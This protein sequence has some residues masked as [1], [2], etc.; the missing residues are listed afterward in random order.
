MG[1]SVLHLQGQRPEMH[2][3]VAS[4]AANES[5]WTCIMTNLSSMASSSLSRPSASTGVP[6]GPEAVAATLR[7]AR[8]SAIWAW[9]WSICACALSSD[10]LSS[11]R[12]P[13]NAKP[14]GP[15]ATADGLTAS[16]ALASSTLLARREKEA[17]ASRNIF[18][19][20]WLF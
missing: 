2:G 5:I 17:S 1:A 3:H 4:P 12:R 13:M 20:P 15:A 14:F 6:T 16:D 8:T 9:I 10:F 7:A 19:M 11:A 18:W